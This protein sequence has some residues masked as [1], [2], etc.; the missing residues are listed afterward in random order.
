MNFLNTVN[1]ELQVKYFNEFWNLGG[2]KN[3]M[4]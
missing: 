4:P 1:E 3:W 2:N